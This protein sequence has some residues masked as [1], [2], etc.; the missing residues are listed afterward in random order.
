MYFYQ[1]CLDLILTDS[2]ERRTVSFI[3]QMRENG[4]R[5]VKLS[6]SKGWSLAWK[7]IS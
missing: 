4:I 2:W 3:L 5:E 1:N 7:Q 6:S